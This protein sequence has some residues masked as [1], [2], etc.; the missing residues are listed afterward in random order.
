MGRTAGVR[1]AGK[2]GARGGVFA[3]CGFVRSQIDAVDLVAGDVALEPLDFRAHAFEDGQ[4]FAGDFLKL[5]IGHVAGTGYFSL[6][7]KLRHMVTSG[8]RTAD[9]HHCSVWKEACSQVGLSY[10]TPREG[11]ATRDLNWFQKPLK[12]Q[13]RNDPSAS[14]ITL[15]AKG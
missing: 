1:L 8:A 2:R 12:E 10:T 14:R 15:K 7:N 11:G 6:D 3:D 13:Y 4:R 5:G 9:K